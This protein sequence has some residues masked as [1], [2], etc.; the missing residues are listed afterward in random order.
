MSGP[1]HASRAAARTTRLLGTVLGITLL[2]S[3]CSGQSSSS[4]AGESTPAASTAGGSSA[5]AST[6]PTA[7]P[8]GSPTSSSTATGVA[9]GSATLPAAPPTA[10]VPV[11]ATT[12]ALTKR[13]TTV[14]IEAAT[15]ARQRPDATPS[16]LRKSAT[17]GALSSVT[18]ALAELQANHWRQVG[19]P[20]VVKQHV[21]SY[22]GTRRPPR[23]KLAVCVDTS[24][25]KVV[26]KSGTT[27][28]NSV[29]TDRTWNLYTLIKHSG[30]WLVA[31]QS[32]PDDPSC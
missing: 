7:V 11:P 4:A 17:K 12:R 1:E 22:D 31:D 13:K 25:V 10:V 2:A 16:R 3:S 29:N 6:R 32:F 5:G 24:D 28:P 30:E 23:M 21:V 9:P 15:A 20:H 27:V 18:T 26:D 8:S 19:K 14:F